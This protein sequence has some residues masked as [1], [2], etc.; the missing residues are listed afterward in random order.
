M[1][2]KKVERALYGPSWTE[3]ILGAALSFVLGLVLAAA[4]LIA[5]PVKTVRELPKEADREREVIYYIEGSKDS[6]KGRQ[7]QAKRQQ[8][9]AGESVALTEEELNTA[10][11]AKT[12]APAPAPAPVAPAPKGKGPAPKTPAPAPAPATPPAPAVAAN[13]GLIVPSAPNFRIHDNVLQVG[14][15]CTLNVY[16]FQ[17]PV[18]VLAS[19][20]FAKTDDGIV[21][22][23]DSFY[24]GSLQVKRLPAL[25][26]FVTKKILAAQTIPEDLST[27]WKKV[28]DAGIEGKTLKLSM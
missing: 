9:V 16:G 22:A 7:W 18:V 12:S 11:G 6:T 17:L 10:F 25:E 26:G 23:P 28:T 24:I 13:A 19:G 4:V 20:G 8:L 21:F 2:S 14:V 1:S 3:V 27:A 15:P 5:R